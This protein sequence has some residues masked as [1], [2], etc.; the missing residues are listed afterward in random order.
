MSIIGEIITTSGF[1]EVIFGSPKKPYWRGHG[2]KD[3]YNLKSGGN[4][5]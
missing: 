3:D 5:N 1:S 4:F 2:R